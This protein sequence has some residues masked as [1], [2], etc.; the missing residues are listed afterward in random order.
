MV[1]LGLDGRLKLQISFFFGNRSVQQGS[2]F[3]RMLPAVLLQAALRFADNLS[4]VS[5][6]RTSRERLVWCKENVGLSRANAYRARDLVR[7]GWKVEN[8]LVQTV[9]SWEKLAVVWTKEARLAIRSLAFLNAS[10][11]VHKDLLT[12]KNLR[13]LHVVRW[14]P[15]NPTSDHLDFS[16]FV[17]LVDV[18]LSTAI[19]HAIKKMTFSD[20]VAELGFEPDWNGIHG[21][22]PFIEA[23]GLTSLEIRGSL[24]IQWKDVDMPRLES[25][26][27]F[28]AL[29]DLEV[30]LPPL[31]STRLT[32]LTVEGFP[33]SRLDLSYLAGLRELSLV[34]RA[35]LQLDQC[36]FLSFPR[37]LEFLK[38]KARVGTEQRIDLDVLGP[39]CP[40]LKRVHIS[41]ACNTPT[42][43]LDVTAW[44][45]CSKLGIVSVGQLLMPVNLPEHP[46]RIWPELIDMEL[47]GQDGTHGWYRNSGWSHE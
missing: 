31:R 5:F 40:E 36:A 1:V 41:L 46:N 27:Y 11:A 45:A 44:S 3:L 13:S 38:L 20:A 26:L 37:T 8:L 23:R 22:L 7:I 12:C 24:P 14:D 33:P 47:L 34:S 42:I 43:Y 28:D 39:Q 21:T 25:L 29:H 10:W 30:L 4:L 15:L 32:S 17:K 6:A 18:R 2:P 19:S 9:D 35:H 16:A